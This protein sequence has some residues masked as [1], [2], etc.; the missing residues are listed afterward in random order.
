MIKNSLLLGLALVSVVCPAFG[1]DTVTFAPED[2]FKHDAAEVKLTFNPDVTVDAGTYTV[3]VGGYTGSFEVAAGGT[4]TQVTGAIHFDVN[5]PSSVFIDAPLEG[6]AYDSNHLLP[7]INGQVPYSV[8]V[9]DGSSF[10]SH[11]RAGQLWQLFRTIGG[12]PY[13]T[14][15][16]IKDKAWGDLYSVSFQDLSP[17]LTITVTTPS[18]AINLP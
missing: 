10:K 14:T 18:G 15:F 5:K 12:N 9:P 2:G 1:L 16:T 7:S 8:T 6:W 11:I 13:G 17:A 4:I 3:T